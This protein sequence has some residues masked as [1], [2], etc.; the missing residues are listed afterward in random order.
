MTAPGERLN[1][2]RDPADGGTGADWPVQATQTIVRTVDTVRD[3]TSGPAR[4]AVAGIVYGLIA[5][6]AVTVLGVMVV[7]AG[8]RGLELLLWDKVWLAYTVLGG[9]FSLAGLLC[10]AKR[11]RL[12]AASTS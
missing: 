12:R 1:P 9:V 2:P 5:A 6:A 11:P 10:W 8:V 3:K 7:I 4:T